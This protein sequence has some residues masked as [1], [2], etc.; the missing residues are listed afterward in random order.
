[1][2]YQKY[3]S[4]L[5][6]PFD[7]MG[8]G[9]FA[10]EDQDG[11]DNTGVDSNLEAAESPVNIKNDKETPVTETPAENS[12]K[13]IKSPF[14]QIPNVH[15]PTR[16]DS[17]LT[18]N[19]IEETEEEKRKVKEEQQQEKGKEER[20]EQEEQEKRNEEQQQEE[21]GREK[22]EKEE[23]LGG[24][25][26]VVGG[27]TE[28]FDMNERKRFNFDITGE[29]MQ[30]IEEFIAKQN[31]QQDTLKQ[32]DTNV[33]Q[34]NI[35]SHTKPTYT[36][37]VVKL[38]GALSSETEKLSLEMKV[39]EKSVELD[40]RF[41]D[42]KSAMMET[43]NAFSVNSKKASLKAMTSTP[44]PPLSQQTTPVTLPLHSKKLPRVAKYSAETDTALSNVS[45]AV[46]TAAK[47]VTFSPTVDINTPQQHENLPQPPQSKASNSTVTTPQQPF[48]PKPE[49]TASNMAYPK[50][51][52]IV[53][54]LPIHEKKPPLTAQ[55]PIAIQQQITPKVPE[56]SADSASFKRNN[57]IS[58]GYYST[59]DP[60]AERDPFEE[61]F[62]KAIAAGSSQV[63]AIAGTPEHVTT[64]TVSTT[65]KALS[66]GSA[67]E[68]VTSNVSNL[69]ESSTTNLS[70]TT[71]LSFQ[72]PPPPPPL[73]F[74][75]SS[76]NVNS[77]GNTKQSN[78]FP[79]PEHATLNEPGQSL[80]T[81]I[82]GSSSISSSSASRSKDSSARKRMGGQLSKDLTA[83]L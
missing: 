44:S 72:S 61:K 57:R 60:T 68:T 7:P 9:T 75:S 26:K 11:P 14:R 56:K 30:E 36:S 38:P 2:D 17:L 73:L 83:Y 6:N 23:E 77:S 22:E 21:A 55:P 65:P 29:E 53:A 79:P 32:L 70:S 35:E 59:L 3:Q 74:S 28:A 40:A 39:S 52:G 48:P 69:K 37:D 47:T 12:K 15:S 4:Y 41:K 67:V 51:I 42:D 82:S 27:E 24:D 5:Q 49:K 78:L 8:M 46:P 66:L 10:V 64:S 20:E 58:R 76:K 18:R 19:P 54:G 63:K 45:P 80:P 50:R 25:V 33:E 16:I 1:M 71:P 13:S 34:D 62:K 43:P 81:A 31:V